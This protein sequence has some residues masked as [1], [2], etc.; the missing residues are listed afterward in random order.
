MM[1]EHVSSS[2]SVKKRDLTFLKCT[3]YDRLYLNYDPKIISTV[4]ADSFTST[5]I[6]Q[7]FGTGTTY[8]YFRF[9][10]FTGIEL[11]TLNNINTYTATI[12][13]K[14]IGEIFGAVL[15]WVS[16]FALI[17]GFLAAPLMDKTLNLLT[18]ESLYHLEPNMENPSLLKFIV[19]GIK[20]GLFPKEDR[21]VKMCEQMEKMKDVGT[22]VKLQALFSRLIPRSRN[23]PSQE[24]IANEHNFNQVAKTEVGVELFSD[25]TGC[26]PLRL[27]VFEDEKQE[28]CLW[29]LKGKLLCLMD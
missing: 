10:L 25:S 22:I 13:R 14:N 15:S 24:L 4:K 12:Y 26:Q 7:N 28:N 8:T 5:N 18:A 29:R 16:I 20:E 23:R 3:I 1:M 2:I 9:Y 6:N 27:E 11:S 19:A 17:I 21:Y